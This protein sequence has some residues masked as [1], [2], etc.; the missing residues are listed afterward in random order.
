MKRSRDGSSN[1][2]FDES[3][4]G[5]DDD[6]DDLSDLCSTGSQ[7]GERQSEGQGLTAAFLPIPNDAV[8]QPSR[9]NGGAGAVG[10]TPRGPADPTPKRRC[11][12]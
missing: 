4:G 10:L 5:D 11:S 7:D 12:I 3:N 2:K 8:D 9:V 1:D 6:D